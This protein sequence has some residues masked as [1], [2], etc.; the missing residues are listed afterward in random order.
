M[1]ETNWTP[2]A[3]LF[4]RAIASLNTYRDL[5]TKIAI[6]CDFFMELIYLKFE[7]DVYTYN[8]W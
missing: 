8:A 7:F 4:I 5:Y 3:G 6:K 2:W 1:K